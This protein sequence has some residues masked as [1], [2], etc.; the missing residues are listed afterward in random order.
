MALTFALDAGRELAPAAALL[1]LLVVPP[2]TR[3]RAS[4]GLAHALPLW[5]LELEDHLLAWHRW[6]D[7]NWA[8]VRGYFT[9]E[10]L[11]YVESRVVLSATAARGG[12]LRFWWT[13]VTYMF[14]HGSYRHLLSNLLALGCAGSGSR[15]VLGNWAALGFFFSG[16]AFAALN[17]STQVTLLTC[18]QCR[19]WSSYGLVS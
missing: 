11:A 18:C 17:A 10:R 9:A 8:G 3:T 13:P 7:R 5:L 15:R 16:G 4:S 14:V 1:A 2:L 12:K 6:V 19:R